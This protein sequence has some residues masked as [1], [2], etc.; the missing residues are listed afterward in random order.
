V[1]SD[2]LLPD[3]GSSED[4]QAAR[5]NRKP[6]KHEHSEQVGENW[7]LGG[8]CRVINDEGIPTCIAYDSINTNFGLDASQQ[9]A[10]KFGVGAAQASSSNAE[11]VSLLVDDWEVL[12]VQQ[13][14]KEY[15]DNASSR[16]SHSS[17]RSSHRWQSILYS[18]EDDHKQ[19]VQ[20]DISFGPAVT[21]S[22]SAIG[23][24]TPT[25]RALAQMKQTEADLR[26]RSENAENDLAVK[27]GVCAHSE[28]IAN[29][30]EQ[31][32]DD[33]QRLQLKQELAESRTRESDLKGSICEL[34]N[35]LHRL[36]SRLN[37]ELARKT[38]NRYRRRSP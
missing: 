17:T 4:E 20:Q 24:T 9:L 33:Y 21:P 11:N 8:V 29:E 35:E 31:R 27:H 18:S 36:R 10:I 22:L 23:Y 32:A 19:D 5:D 7:R 6:S 13:Q 30:E 25:S 34:E 12:E 3:I 37:E 15:S 28:L 2:D 38:S 16:G 26:I 14:K 1:D